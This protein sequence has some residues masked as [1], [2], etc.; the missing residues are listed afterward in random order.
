MHIMQQKQAWPAR[1]GMVAT[2]TVMWQHA[3]MLTGTGVDHGQVMPDVGI[4][5]QGMLASSWGGYALRVLT[6]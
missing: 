3:A 4:M 6:L 5:E 2:A 1:C